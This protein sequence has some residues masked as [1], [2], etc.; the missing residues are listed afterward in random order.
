MIKEYNRKSLYYGIPGLC[1]QIIGVI[2]SSPLLVL[3]GGIFLIVGLCM[4]AKAKGRHY[5]WGFFGLLSWIGII[6]LACLNDESKE[7]VYIN[8]ADPPTH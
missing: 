8:T 4:Y 7:V 2:A 5:A 3:V 1:V 6:V